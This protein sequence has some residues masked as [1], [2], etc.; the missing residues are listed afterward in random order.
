M[1]PFWR[2][3]FEEIKLAYTLKST[4]PEEYKFENVPGKNVS[5]SM[6][7]IPPERKLAPAIN[8]RRVNAIGASID[9]QNPR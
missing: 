8:K 2:A 1:S 7:P 6:S 3:F 9:P 5:D 4:I